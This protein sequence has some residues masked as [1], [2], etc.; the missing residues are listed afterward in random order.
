MQGPG[1]RDP[2]GACPDEG[3]RSRTRDADAS[4]VPAELD[5]P[6]PLVTVPV[7]S[8][9]PRNRHARQTRRLLG[10]TATLLAVLSLS[11]VLSSC[12]STKP[13]L[14]AVRDA[15]NAS[16]A[17]AG[18]PALRENVTLDVKADKWAQGMR[19]ACRIWHSNLADGAPKEWRKL[20]ENVGMGGSIDQIHVAYMNSPGHRANILDPAFNQI[21]TA[22]VWGTC[23]GMRT[24]FTVHVFMKG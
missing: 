5:R 22:A 8:S 6:D 21:G 1:L 4:G 7:G 18:L 2:P 20:G 11:G 24:L 9:S 17:A 12:E 16:R 14:D 10:I 19:D 23:N 13:E 3:S 15:V